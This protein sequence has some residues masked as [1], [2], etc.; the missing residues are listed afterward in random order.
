[1]AGSLITTIQRWKGLANDTKPFGDVRAGSTYLEMDTGKPWI[2]VNKNWYEDLSAPLSIAM[3]TAIGNSQRQLL[4]KLLIET[5]A[6]RELIA[7]L[8]AVAKFI[9]YFFLYFG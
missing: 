7:E 8:V 5:I 2:F 1:M 9:R 6:T 4:E 3:A